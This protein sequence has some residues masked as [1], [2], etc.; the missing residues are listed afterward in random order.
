M[1]DEAKQA[2]ACCA[3]AALG[4][5]GREVVGREK[6]LSLKCFCTSPAGATHCH[7][8]EQN[9]PIGAIRGV[10]FLPA[11][12]CEENVNSGRRFWGDALALRGPKAGFLA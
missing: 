9:V 2:A 8:L 5:G 12:R 10:S 4:L 6:S 7:Q 11:L 1:M 3:V